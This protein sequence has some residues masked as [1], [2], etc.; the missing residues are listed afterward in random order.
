[1][2]EEG[3]SVEVELGVIYIAVEMDIEFAENIDMGKKVD[4]KKKR[5]KE[6]ALGHTCCNTE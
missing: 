1:M 6:R 3:A 4:N 5:S 2:R